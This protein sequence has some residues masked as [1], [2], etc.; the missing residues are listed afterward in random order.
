M[1]Q[2]TQEQLKYE[3]HGLVTASAQANNG[4]TVFILFV[5]YYDR[6]FPSDKESNKNTMDSDTIRHNGLS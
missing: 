4:T 1:G 6:V 5:G 3:T 2:E